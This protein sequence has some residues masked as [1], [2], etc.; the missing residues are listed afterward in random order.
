MSSPNPL[1]DQL[2][3]QAESIVYSPQLATKYKFKEDIDFVEDESGDIVTDFFNCDCNSFVGYILGGPLGSVDQGL[4][5]KHYAKIAALGKEKEPAQPRPRAFIYYQFFA[6]LTPESPGGWHQI[7]LLQDALPGDIMAWEL[8]G[9]QAGDNTG[10]VFFVAAPP[11]SD[12][13]GIFSVQAYD[14]AQYPHF[15]DT[16]G[17]G[18][19]GVGSGVIKFRVNASGGPTSFLFGP[20][21][22]PQ[23]WFTAPIAIGRPKPL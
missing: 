5:P 18:E 17:D 13:H 15:D 10:H 14:S 2:A 22:D 4:S 21:D 3:S 12:G 20:P 16:R 19:S 6:S 1:P 11:I 7:K 8:P 9:F 23:N